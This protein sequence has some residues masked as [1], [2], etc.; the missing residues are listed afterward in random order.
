M[1]RIVRL[2]AMSRLELTVV[3]TANILSKLQCVLPCF[4]IVHIAYNW[5]YLSVIKLFV[6][7]IGI[8]PTSR[9]LFCPRHVYNI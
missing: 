2:F 8:L 6:G 4:K 1:I 5:V 3:N 9:F 7:L